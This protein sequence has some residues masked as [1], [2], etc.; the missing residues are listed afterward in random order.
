MIK[1]IVS[2]GLK[3]GAAMAV[4]ETVAPKIK[5]V[6]H[7]AC[8]TVADATRDSDQ[9]AGSEDDEQQRCC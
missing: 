5:R 6:L 7:K 9:T 3:L 1:S 4:A 2:Q 8:Q